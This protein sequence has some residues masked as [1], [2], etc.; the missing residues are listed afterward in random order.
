[1]FRVG[2]TGGIGSGKTTVADMFVELGAEL[3]DTDRIAREVVAPGSTTLNSIREAFGESILLKD[4][5]LDRS[6]LRD[7][8]FANDAERRKL[9]SIIHPVIR[10]RTI[11][12]IETCDGPY[13][14]VAVALLVE[15]DFRELVDCITVVHC[16]I[17]Q[18]IDRVMKR[19]GASEEH[20]KAIIASQADEATRLEAAVDIIDNSKSLAY[21]RDQVERLHRKYL[22]EPDHCRAAKGA[23]K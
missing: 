4:E 8:I 5:S 16:T 13:V 20:A 2:L 15:S 11:R 6:A 9:E 21:T 17:E 7:I 1:M 10:A 14:I 19:D 3:V 12:D 18:Q 23:A 22:S